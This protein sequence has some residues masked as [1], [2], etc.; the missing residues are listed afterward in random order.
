MSDV[1]NEPPSHALVWYK[2]KNNIAVVGVK[3]LY[4]Y[5]VPDD[6]KNFV[7]DKFI[8]VKKKK[9]KVEAILLAVGS[10]YTE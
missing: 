8:Q 2:E 9:L 3:K 1:L 6:G 4:N 7:R 5:I 10:E